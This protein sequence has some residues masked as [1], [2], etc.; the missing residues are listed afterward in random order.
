MRGKVTKRSVDALKPKKAGD[1][2]LW[3]RETRGFG[4]RVK[5]SGATSFMV[6]YYAPGL[7]L[8]RRR[9]TL[10]AYGPLTPD[11][12]RTQATALLARVAKGDDPAKET[13]EG[14]RSAKEETVA[15]LFE[16]YKEDGVGRRKPRTM[17]FYESLGR[18]YIM[19]ALGHLPVAKVAARDV[20]ELHRSLRK[21]PV[22]ANR[23]GK[24]VRSFF[25]WLAKRDLVTG[26][27]PAKDIEWF[28]EQGRERF[29]TVDEMARLGSAVRIAETVGLP[30]APEHEDE[31]EKR[32]AHPKRREPNAGM[33]KS[34]LQPANPVA[35]AALRF[36]MFTGWREQEALTLAWADVDLGRG[37][38][39]LTDTKSRK[40]VR[41]LS[42]PAKE[43]LA[44][45]VRVEGSP[46]V[47][48]G[49]DPMKPLREIQR[50][51]YA[52]R[53]KAGLGDVRLHDLRHSVASFAGGRGYSLFLIGK[54][55]GHRDQ[56]STERYAHLAD[57]IRKTMADDVGEGI[58]E[59]MEADPKVISIKA[60]KT[61]R[62]K[63]SK[64]RPSGRR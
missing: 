17:E 25:Y 20:A 29:L 16:Q 43:L 35:V 37:F 30:P 64:A 58:R 18:L 8:V 12:A 48:P 6:A 33:F 11:A 3:D 47:F 10:G 49:R 28:P 7:H 46:Y 15:R 42:A 45:Q 54:L 56:R 23:V 31:L 61:T 21:K 22:T 32:K 9:V 52:A 39:T 14:R 62:H 5:P 24:L 38:A 60:K 50:L 13:A 27:N 57:D 4:V 36:L 19:P 63:R 1:L 34:E 51:W 41:T 44:G 40:S 26:K 59:A 53:A 55:L 2:F